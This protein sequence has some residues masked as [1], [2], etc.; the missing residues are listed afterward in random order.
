M[1]DEV[2]ASENVTAQ[3][4]SRWVANVDCHSVT[5][6]YHDGEMKYV[7]KRA[8]FNTGD[9]DVSLSMRFVR[10]NDQKVYVR[11]CTHAEFVAIWS[12]DLGA[13]EIR[14]WFEDP[15][16]AIPLSQEYVLILKNPVEDRTMTLES[17]M[18][19]VV[20]DEKVHQK[21]EEARATEDRLTNE[22]E[23]LKRAHREEIMEIRGWASGSIPE[24]L[25]K[26]LKA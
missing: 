6:K 3:S 9:V 26:K 8:T 22:I 11:K 15:I 16:F 12:L 10:T 13:A 21:S 20:L 19:F 14:K 2:K 5:L 18:V 23:S 1:T 4:P 17:H 25:P 7:L 24:P